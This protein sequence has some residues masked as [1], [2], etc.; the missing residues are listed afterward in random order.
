MYQSITDHTSVA[1][2]K[3]FKDPSSLD[4]HAKLLD[5]LLTKHFGA[6]GNSRYGTL[7]FF[8]ALR[9]RGPSEK[10]GFGSVFRRVRN[11]ISEATSFEMP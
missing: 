11:W 5:R 8:N 2:H 3:R 10:E 9:I 4:S 6:S 1:I 7:V